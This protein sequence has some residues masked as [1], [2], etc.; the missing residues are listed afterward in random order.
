MP[1]YYRRVVTHWLTSAKREET[2]ERRFATLLEHSR[3]GRRIPPFDPAPPP[4]ASRRP[5][6]PRKA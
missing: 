5:K 2:R 1:P 6:P 4:A 3:R